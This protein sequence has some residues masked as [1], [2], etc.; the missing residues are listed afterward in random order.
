M[1][2]ILILL[3]SA[4]LVCTRESKDPEP[5]SLGVAYAWVFGTV[6]AAA[7]PT[8]L[9]IG[10]DTYSDSYD[11]IQAL[12]FIIIPIG[13]S[14]APSMGRFYAGDYKGGWGG[15]GL[16]LGALVATVAIVAPCLFGGCNE[17]LAV[18]PLAGIGV[19]FG[20]AVYDTFWGTYR[21]VQKHNAKISL[22][23]YI[24]RFG[25]AGVLARLDF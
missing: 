10:R 11:K 8:L 12:N 18:V 22:S 6:A 5:K 2:S 21:S 13:W 4:S 17:A 1:K 23:P 25:S 24:P 7:A 15:T 19:W 9:L 14:V 3:L 20:S 16:R